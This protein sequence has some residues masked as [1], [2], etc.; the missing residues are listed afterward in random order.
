MAGVKG[1]SNKRGVARREAILK[2]AIAAIEREGRTCL[3][4]GRGSRRGG[5]HAG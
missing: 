2:A 1:Q 5:R 3:D 4:A